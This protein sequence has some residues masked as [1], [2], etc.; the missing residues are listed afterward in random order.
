LLQPARLPHCLTVAAAFLGNASVTAQSA[1]A[2]LYPKFELSLAVPAVILNSD[3]RVDGSGGRIGTDL[4]AEDD[5]GLAKTKFQPRVALRW[6]PGRRHE[7]EVGYQFARRTG[8]TILEREIDFVDST[9][10]VGTPV[11]SRFDSDQAFLVYR[12][13]FLARDRTQVGAALGLG[14]LFLDIGLDELVAGTGGDEV[15]FSQS[16]TVTGPLGSIGL[17]GRFLAG[18]RWRFGAD[19]RYIDVSIDRFQPRVLEAGLEVLYAFSPSVAVEAGY[20]G[21]AIRMDV[22]PK[23]RAP[24]ETGLVSGQIKYSLQ[25]VRLGVALTP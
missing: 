4:D 11:R 3:I 14:A 22:G 9:Y 1:K 10:E 21:S 7:L 15:D 12:F 20:G 23:T 24:G 25:N 19:L 17:F 2:N 16:A 18:D 13:A 5:L 8:E 6:R